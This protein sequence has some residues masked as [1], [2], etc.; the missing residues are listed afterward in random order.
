MSK[1]IETDS[2]FNITPKMERAVARAFEMYDNDD[3]IEVPLRDHLGAQFRKG[4]SCDHRWKPAPQEEVVA[5]CFQKVFEES[6]IELGFYCTVCGA[7]C[8]RENGQIWAYDATTRFFGRVPKERTN[9]QSQ[10]RE[11]K[12]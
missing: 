6:A 5:A 10:R 9:D 3:A 11:R 8:L 2:K 4:V 12:V 1:I 7:T